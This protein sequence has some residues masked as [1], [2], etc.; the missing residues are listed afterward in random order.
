MRLENED[1]EYRGI[2]VEVHTDDDPL[3]PLLDCDPLGHYVCFHGR[4]NLGTKHSFKDP[5]ELDKFMKETP[6]AY[7]SPLYL[8]DHSGLTISASPFSCPWDSGQVGYMYVTEEQ[9]EKEYGKLTDEVLDKIERVMISQLEE[10]DYYLQGASYGFHIPELEESCWGFLGH[11]HEE[12]GLVEAAKSI[13]LTN[14]H[15]RECVNS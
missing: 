3:N 10:Y 9:A 7:S 12:S 4:Y 13:I 15:H 11:D 2:N 1:F 8:Y 5:E 6:L 14:K